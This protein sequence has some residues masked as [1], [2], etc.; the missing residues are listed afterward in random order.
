M[1]VY[2]KDGDGMEYQKFK[3]GRHI[4]CMENESRLGFFIEHRTGSAIEK[5]VPQSVL[6]QYK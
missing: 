6:N 5:V 2:R 1:A 3:K 4:I